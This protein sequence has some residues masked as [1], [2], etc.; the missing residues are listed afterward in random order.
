M[1]SNWSERREKNP[2]RAEDRLPA[3]E[4]IPGLKASTLPWSWMNQDRRGLRRRD[5][6]GYLLSTSRADR[7]FAISIP[8]RGLSSSKSDLFWNLFRKQAVLASSLSPSVPEHQPSD[9][10]PHSRRALRTSAPRMHKPSTAQWLYDFRASPF[11][12]FPCCDTRRA[13]S[14]KSPL[15]RPKS[16]PADR[17]YS[18]AWSRRFRQLTA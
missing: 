10:A 7:A 4:C 1:G 14:R 6:P 2:C 12:R 17:I 8:E 9:S 5:C 16:S 11:Q 13:A 3:E 15:K 18:C